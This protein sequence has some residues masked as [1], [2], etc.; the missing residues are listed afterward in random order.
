MT[1]S[2]V[3]YHVVSDYVSIHKFTSVSGNTY[4]ILFIYIKHTIYTK[5]LSGF[6]DENSF[7]KICIF[8]D[9]SI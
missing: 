2:W 3:I 1:D 5:E 7:P 4:H 6:G 8:L 9:H